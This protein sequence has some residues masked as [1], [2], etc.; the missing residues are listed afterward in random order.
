MSQLRLEE[1]EPT[2][3]KIKE[4]LAEVKQLIDR[5]D[6][7]ANVKPIAKELIAA[8]IAAYLNAKLPPYEE[9]ELSRFTEALEKAQKGIN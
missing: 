7:E 8:I 6:W 5:E 9:I 2:L 1:L 4:A 3:A